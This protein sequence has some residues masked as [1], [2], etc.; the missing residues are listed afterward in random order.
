M[1]GSDEPDRSA[2]SGVQPARS[3]RRTRPRRRWLGLALKTLIP[4]LL[5]AGGIAGFRYLTAT[6]PEPVAKPAQEQR[7]TV[8]A[9]RIT[10]GTMRPALRLFGRITA[11]TP[12][13]LRAGVAGFVRERDENLVRGGIVRAG[14]L[15]VVL[16]ER[17]LRLARDEAEA[18]LAEARARLTELQAQLSSERTMLSID[19]ELARLAETNLERRRNLQRRGVTSE[20]ALDQAQSEAQTAR[21]VVEQAKS[22]IAVTEARVEQQSAVVA[23][24]EAALAQARIDLDR[25]R[26]EA[27]ETAIVQSASATVGGRVEVNS[28]I[29][30]L[31]P[32]SGLEAEFRMSS[33]EYGRLVGDDR[34][35]I[36]RGAAL[37]W[38]AGARPLAGRVVRVDPEVD[39]AGGGILVYAALPALTVD[40]PLRPGTFLSVEIEDAAFPSV[41]RLPATALMPDGNVY[42]VDQE[43]RLAGI[44]VTVVRRL[45]DQVLVRGELT[46][47]ACIVTTRF[48]RIGTG[49]A[50]DAEGC[51]PRSEVVVTDPQASAS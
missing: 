12:L 28:E 24:A 30:T 23:R 16:D 51:G 34:P 9:Q 43:G 39:E 32:L 11:R 18:D 6:R 42:A 22:N 10:V 41:A 20:D 13:V 21:R 35:L 15:L 14:E 27:P 5:L 37:H 4:L 31:L 45:D 19:R 49:V 3:L 33:V 17:D 44:P 48:N 29:A 46:D 26:V 25:A 38:Q 1:A 50:V 2:A 36:G 8:A 40:T 7:W 47:G